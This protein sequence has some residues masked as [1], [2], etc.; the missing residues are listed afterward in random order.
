MGNLRSQRF[1]T[2][3]VLLG[4]LIVW[5]VASLI[6]G[7]GILSSPAAT[8]IRAGSLVAGKTLWVQ[9][10]STGHTLL[11]ACAIVFGVGLSM[12]CLVG[13][14]RLAS[15]VVE[16]VLAPMYAIPKIALYPIIL[17]VFG[18][19]PAATI[20]FAALHGI[21]PVMI[22]TIG[23]IRK[24][25]PIYLQTA[26]VMRLT[27]RRT[28]VSILAPAAMPE[29][30]AGLRVGFATTLFGAL[31]A[32]LFASTGGIGFMLIRATDAHNMTDVMAITLL[33]FVFAIAANG[34]I[35][36]LESRVRHGNT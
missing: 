25:K 21:F 32:E 29:I 8:L 30:V 14:S 9:A 20:V 33:L 28:I 16:P 35:T 23:G 24:I 15:D 2:A 26:R 1:D 22:F 7:K 36:W 18:L 5:E 10:A 12:G 17:L 6:I 4:F 11:L 19:T 27:T 13:A 31:I 34:L 3:F